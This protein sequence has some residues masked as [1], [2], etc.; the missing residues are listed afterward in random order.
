[1]IAL[2]LLPVSWQQLLVYERDAVAAGQW[3]RLLTGN[4]V[5]LGWTHLALNAAAMLIGAL[6][7]EGVRTPASW[8][9]AAALCMLA[10][11]LGL[12]FLSPDV[13]WSMGISG[14]LHGLL[15]V[16]AVDLCVRRDWVG[17]VL[18]TL[19]MAKVTT[20]QFIGGGSPTESLIGAPVVVDAH[21][22]GALGGLAFA[23]A[24]RAFRRRR[25][26]PTA[27]ARQP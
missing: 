25:K 7:L 19:C 22:W 15:V 3:W 17:P 24:D 11:S 1:M 14:V 2:Q 5:H 10:V 18:L 16:G 12:Y 26:A 23:V 27:P 9:L 6:L 4:L 8:L 13:Q 20:E 21:L